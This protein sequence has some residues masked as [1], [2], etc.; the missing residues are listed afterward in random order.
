AAL[1]AMNDRDRAT[2]IA[3]ARNAPIAQAEIHLA[4]GDR[5]IG[6]RLFLQP[7]R[8]FFLRSRSGH[9]VEEARIDQAAVAVIG[10]VGDD[11][12]FRIDIGRANNGRVAELVFVGEFEVALV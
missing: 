6:R 12:A 9:A 11:E 10:D 4:L 5:T 2:P 3:L 7:L 8:D 1:F